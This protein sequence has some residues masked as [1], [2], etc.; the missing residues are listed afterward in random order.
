MSLE[1]PS[2]PAPA[3]RAALAAGS[4]T[5]SVFVEEDAAALELLGDP[6]PLPDL[7]EA[8]LAAYGAGGI[9]EV[10]LAKRRYLASLAARDLAGEL[11]LESVGSGLAALADG[12]LAAG[13]KA[14]DAPPGLAVIAMGK[15]G[16]SELNYS[17]DIDLMFVADGDLDAATKAATVLVNLLGDFSPQGQA[18]RID[19][20]LRPEGRSGALVRSLD[21][22][23]EY[24]KRWA[25]DWEY[26]AL[27]KARCAAGDAELGARFIEET[28]PFVYAQQVS[29]ERVL[30][31]RRMKER[32]EGHAQMTAK[33][34]KTTDQFDV[35]LGPGGIRDIEFSVQL[36]QLVHGGNDPT[37]RGGATLPALSA[38]VDHG[39]VA[40]DDGAGLAV[41]Y[42]WLRNVEHRLQLWQERQVHHLPSEP[43]ALSRVGRVL[44]FKDAPV[45][46]A[47][48]R[49]IDAH[50]A[51]LSDVRGRFEKLFYR[52]MIEALAE[53]GDRRLSPEA[54][55]ERLHVLGFRDVERA[56]RTLEGL[57][58]GSSRRAKLFRVLTPALLRFL[59]ATPAPDDGLF[60]FLKLG[61]VLQDRLDVLGL[62][63]D[64]PPGLQLLAEVLGTGRY[65]GERLAQVPDEIATIA[66]PRDTGELKDGDR[67]AR[68]AVASLEWRGPDRL[69]E[70]LRRFKR[71]EMLRVAVADVG[72]TA[73]VEEVGSA[74]SDLADACLE[75]ALQ[76]APIPFAVVGMGKLGGRELGYAS[77]I[78]VMFVFEGDA[79]AGE[80]T[81]AALLKTIG[82]V[83]PEGQT[84][85]V[86]AGL[87]PEGKAGPLARSLQSYL[88]YYA[89]WSDPWE[90]QALIK[91]RHAAGD[92]ELG[93]RLV[94][95]TRA[96][97][98]PERVSQTDLAH[99]RNLKARMERER[100]PRGT[101]P[102]RHLKMGPGGMADVEFAVQLLQLQHGRHIPFLQVTGTLAALDAVRVAELL[103]AEDVVQ[104]AESYRFLS[105]LRDRAFFL[106]GRPADALPA[107]PEEMEGLGIAMGFTDQPRQELEEHFFRV[108][109]RSRKICEKV[110]F[111]GAA[112]AG[113]PQR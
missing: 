30:E 86:D 40:E 3:R 91:A 7:A 23:L 58:S 53:A 19:L 57:V 48:E 102:R 96:F 85:Q 56:S 105:R 68:E 10:R 103:R 67:L 51:V 62:L 41:A 11:D 17:S 35:K 90:Q 98:F 54:V 52:P 37:V 5:L 84:F 73:A 80:K 21:G 83:T 94:R 46:S 106:S 15:L 82:D 28:H 77:D 75:A 26:Q 1:H 25:K 100:I 4:K 81:A 95:E 36:L 13:L 93:E 74:L 70:G 88:E 109:R 9:P 104:L 79:V 107:K 55:Q 78:D 66:D 2:D 72:G 112:N 63:R 45:A 39:Y 38:L 18:Y 87:R 22:Y 8:M 44:G 65:L 110:I 43:E 16:G 32:V 59:S 99:I 113:Q 69:L 111:G 97:A 101:D 33:R 64:N 6:G 89:R 92:R 31:I 50:R 14:A 42:R 24:Y 61:E 34:S 29:A 76:D 47:G 60:A 49:F 12:C 20:N 108:T 27:I 71:R